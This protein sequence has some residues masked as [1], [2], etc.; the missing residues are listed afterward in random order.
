MPQLLIFAG[1]AV[2]G[3]LFSDGV[4]ASSRLVKW[5][6]IAGGGYLLW[7]SGVLKK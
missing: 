7:K 3:F 6:T 4:D 2:A 1:G 5:G